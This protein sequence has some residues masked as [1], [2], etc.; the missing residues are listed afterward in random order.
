MEEI[1]KDIKGFENKYQVSNLGRVRS[2]KHS[3]GYRDKPKILNGSLDS[4]G[5]KQVNL[6]KNGNRKLM[7]MHRLVAMAFIP[8]PNQYPYINHKDE[9]P[10]NNSVWNL[11]WCTA[12]YN[13]TYG[14]AQ[15]WKFK[16][17]KM[18][19]TINK[20]VKSYKSIAEASK[21]LNIPTTTIVNVLH[22]NSTMKN[23]LDFKYI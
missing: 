18:I 6:C 16:P 7:F 20:D 10:L 2:L 1:W 19:N 8:N 4:H 22:R 3:H 14:R 12:Q 15:D 21:D 17:I 9:N 11:E 5:Y 23:G 13:S